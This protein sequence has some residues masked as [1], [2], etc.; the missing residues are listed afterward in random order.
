M[1]CGHVR[2]YLWGKLNEGHRR[3]LCNIFA[4]AC[5]SKII[6]QWKGFFFFN[7]EVLYK[8]INLKFRCD[9]SIHWEYVA[10]DIDASVARNLVASH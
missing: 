8:Q 4:A 9:D 1:Y 3:I 2:C 6:S 10:L 7:G 5:E